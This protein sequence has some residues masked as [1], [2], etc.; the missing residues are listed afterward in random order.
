MHGF[1]DRGAFCDRVV[2]EMPAG[3]WMRLL[4]VVRFRVQKMRPAQEAQMWKEGGYCHFGKGRRETG[5]PVVRNTRAR[6]RK[7]AVLQAGKWIGI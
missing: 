4:S 3:R 2:L 7:Q 1:G 5:F 6:C